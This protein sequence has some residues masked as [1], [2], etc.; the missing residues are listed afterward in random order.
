MRSGIT[1]KGR[2]IDH[3]VPMSAGGPELDMSNLQTLCHKCHSSK[4]GK[5]MGNRFQTTTCN[6]EIILVVGPPASGKSHYVRQH[7]TYGDCVVDIDELVRALS[8]NQLRDNAENIIGVALEIRS[9]IITAAI[10]KV[11]RVWVIATGST[12]DSRQR[13]LG[14]HNA[15]QTI[16]M[17]TSRAECKAR[18]LERTGYPEWEHLIDEWF[19]TQDLG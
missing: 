5:E 9:A 14:S 16:V 10:G 7:M 3:I 4:T 17:T 8:L 12:Q 1:V 19:Q 13:A 15:H 2:D 11:A 6:T 18:A